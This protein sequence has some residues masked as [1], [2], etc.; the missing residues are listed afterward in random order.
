MIKVTVTE[1]SITIND[2]VYARVSPD[3]AREI[4]RQLTE[5]L[6]GIGNAER[7][8]TESCKCPA[9]MRKGHIEASEQ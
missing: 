8:L 5:V 1:I 7:A 2:G 3:E 9:P 4:H 6:I